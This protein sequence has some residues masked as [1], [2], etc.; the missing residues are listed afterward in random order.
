MRGCMRSAC[1]CP[2]ACRV[3]ISCLYHRLF[4]ASLDVSCLH[5]IDEQTKLREGETPCPWPCSDKVA[6][7]LQQPALRGR[8]E[9]VFSV[10]CWHITEPGEGVGREGRGVRSG[11]RSLQGGGEKKGRRRRALPFLVETWGRYGGSSW[12]AGDL[13]SDP[14]PPLSSM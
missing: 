11:P 3:F 10:G 1:R 4:P 8:L 14:V 12:R 7:R 2:E 6:P 5:F 9:G 13:S